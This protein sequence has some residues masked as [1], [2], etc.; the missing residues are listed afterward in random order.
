MT[1]GGSG[2]HIYPLLAIRSCFPEADVLYVG[3]RGHLEETIV[4]REGLRFVALPVS[5]FNRKHPLAKGLA[6]LKAV[7]ALQ[8]S[9]IWLRRTR[10]FAV[11]GTGGYVTLPV[12]Y[13]GTLLGIPLF[14]L[15]ANVMPGLANRLLMRRA[16]RI[17]VAFEGT[18]PLLPPSVRARAVVSGFPVRPEV[19]RHERDEARRDLGIPLAATV[20][21]VVGGSQG[22]EALNRGAALLI[23]AGLPLYVLWA[24][25]P[26]Y[27]PRWRGYAAS[28]VD[29]RPYIDDMPRA[30]A[31]ADLVLARAG[32]STLSEITARGL[33][34]ILIPS[35]N[36]PDDHQRKNALYLERRGAAVVIDEDDLER[37]LV[38]QVEHLLDPAKRAAMAEAAKALG[39]PDA[40]RVIAETIR[41]EVGL[42]TRR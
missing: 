34:S 35:P 1:G 6:V 39:R 16:R 3:A 42:R 18:L 11:V 28:H 17:F 26:R 20:L 32:S 13:A 23:E 4:P 24:T 30:L 29:V 38:Q 37:H 8:T 40:A 14:I 31:A 22:A 36:V 5:G 9:L 25:G 2:G 27:F 15:E 7:T 21:L 41:K 33:P 19:L 12:G 10:P